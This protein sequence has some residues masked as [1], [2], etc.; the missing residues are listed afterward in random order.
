MKTLRTG[1]G[2][3]DN[4]DPSEFHKDPALTRL[5]TGARATAIQNRQAQNQTPEGMSN[6]DAQLLEKMLTIAGLR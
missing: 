4:L 3:I 1:P 2:G 6:S 5:A